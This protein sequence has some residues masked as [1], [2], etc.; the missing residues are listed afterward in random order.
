MLRWDLRICG[1]PGELR[2]CGLKETDAL[3]F[4]DDWF[5]PAPENWPGRW[6]GGRGESSLF[7]PRPTSSVSFSTPPLL[8]NLFPFLPFWRIPKPAHLI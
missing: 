8:F 2:S 6:R 3:C 5:L 4:R 7:L 1:R